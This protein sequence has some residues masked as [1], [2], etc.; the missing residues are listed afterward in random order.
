M[1]GQHTPLRPQAPNN[2]TNKP[3]AHRTEQ[4]REVA[5]GLISWNELIGER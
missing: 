2:R 4:T 5:S 1:N 3:S